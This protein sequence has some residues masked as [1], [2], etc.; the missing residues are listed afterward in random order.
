MARFIFVSPV[1]FEP[2]DFRSPDTTGIGGSETAHIETARRLAAMGHEVISYAPVRD[3]CPAEDRG[4]VWKHI[5]DADHD[6]DGIWVISRAPDYIHKLPNLGGRQTA[7][8][9]CQD[10]DYSHRRGIRGKR[11]NDYAG[12]DMIFALC[13]YQLSYLRKKYPELQNRFFLSRNGVRTDLIEQIEAEGIERDPMKIIHTSS[14]DRGLL[15]SLH[16]F[17]RIQEYIPDVQFY[18]A[19]GFDNMRKRIK[20]IA[21]QADE[22]AAKLNETPG[23]TWGERQPQDALYRHFLSS[24]HYLYITDFPETSCIS[25]M[26]AQCMGAIPISSSLWALGDYVRW[27]K[28]IHGTAEHSFTRAQAAMALTENVINVLTKPEETEEYRQNMMTWAREM[29]SWDRVAEQYHALATGEPD[30]SAE[31]LEEEYHRPSRIANR[32]VFQVLNAT[33]KIINLASGHDPYGLKRN[34]G[35]FNVDYH[36]RDIAGAEAAYAVDLKADIRSLPVVHHGKYDTAV[37]GDILEH[38]EPEDGIKILQE[39]NNCL[40][41][42]G[43]VVITMPEDT[44]PVFAQRG[45]EDESLMYVDQIS[46]GHKH[47]T[48]DMLFDWMHKANFMIRH[49]DAINYRDAGIDMGWGV[50]GIKAG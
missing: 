44:R 37:L 23:V 11:V 39:A 35:A 31:L 17:K 33:G 46:Y 41:P 12:F 50:I 29:F 48:R 32:G 43:K 22:I 21:D 18:S 16:I 19:Y 5:D 47:V 3:D 2:W 25:C 4:V 10:V 1:H 26:E 40:R 30:R 42:G 15:P 9:V 7:W 6:L 8:L 28:V 34:K 36:E 14:P 27:G 24:S 13:P 20:E 38:C 49:C 45:Y